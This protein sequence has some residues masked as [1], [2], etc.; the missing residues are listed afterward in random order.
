M[1]EAIGELRCPRCQDDITICPC[2]PGSNRAMYNIART[3]RTA[4]A[5]RLLP[6]LRHRFGEETLRQAAQQSPSYAAAPNLPEPQTRVLYDVDPPTHE[7]AVVKSRTQCEAIAS[8]MGRREKL[9]ADHPEALG[10]VQW[11]ALHII[12]SYLTFD[13]VSK[14]T[15]LRRQKALEPETRGLVRNCLARML[16]RAYTMSSF[17]SWQPRLTW[18]F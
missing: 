2:P 17:P 5:Q 8:L 18:E 1:H 9:F 6:N 13:N 7:S 14:S 3:F 11:S 16:F 15:C 4:E 10:H 12:G